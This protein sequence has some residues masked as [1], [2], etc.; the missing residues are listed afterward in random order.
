MSNDQNK[1]EGHD[2]REPSVQ[3]RRDAMRKMG[4]IA[5]YTAPVVLVA[6]TPTKALRASGIAIPGD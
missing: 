5:A 1:V 2:V 3:A 4:L 6:L